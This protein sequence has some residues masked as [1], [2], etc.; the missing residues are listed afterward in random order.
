MIKLFL[1]VGFPKTGSSTLQKHLFALHP[2]LNYLGRPLSGPLAELE[3][4][5]LTLDDTA[6]EAQLPSYQEQ[7]RAGLE[8]LD[9]R[10]LLLSHEGFLRQTRYGGHDLAV[11]AKRLHRV[12]A[13]GLG[14]RAQIQILITIRNQ[15]DLIL[16]HF[17]QF[18]KGQQKDLDRHLATGLREPG[19]GIFAG[20]FYDD[21]LARYAGLFGAG[22][23]HILVFE[24]FARDQAGFVMQL[25]GILGI[26]GQVALNLLAD[27][28]EKKRQKR[29]NA[30]L[31]QDKKSVWHRS[32]KSLRR[33]GLAALAERVAQGSWSAL[34]WSKQ[35]RRGIDDLY[36]G[37]NAKL[38][39]RY[40]LR[41][42]EFGYPTQDRGD[43]A[44]AN[45]GLGSEG[46]PEQGRS[47]GLTGS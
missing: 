46:A 29:A 24:Q 18:M 22:N 19:E 37:S 45:M 5:I 26:D 8:G 30:Y 47:R 43:T 38:E 16:S 9:N 17:V 23:L 21:L 25:S 35:Q 15:A 27:R 28:H 32:A 7:L 4:G 33:I 39:A 34:A 42:R 41:L 11:T 14:N 6:F 44:G 12:F 2:D 40:G 20:L 10:P 31:V 13:D 36:S 1:H 3:Q